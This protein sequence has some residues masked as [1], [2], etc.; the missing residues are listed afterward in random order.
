KRLKSDET[1]PLMPII[2]VTAKADI[3]DV[4]RGLEIGADEYLTKPIEHAALMA[5]VRSLLRIK[6]LHDTVHAQAKELAEWNR[7]LEERVNAQVGEL[8]RMGRL[9]RFLPRQVAELITSSNQ[10]HLLKSHRREISVMFCDLRGFTGFAEVAE[11]EE[12]MEVL[13]A[14]H[15]ASGDL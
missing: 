5:R 13:H 1:L 2:L 11:P 6:T 14:F 9:K 15:Q 4:V 12:V 10:E 8:E 7:T 3:K